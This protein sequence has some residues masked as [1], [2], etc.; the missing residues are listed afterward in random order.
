MTRVAHVLRKFDPSEWGGTETHVAE[1]TQRMLPLGFQGEVH[2]PAGPSDRSGLHP[3]IPLYRYAA[4]CPYLGPKERRRAL[5]AS[6]GNIVSFNLVTRLAFDRDVALAHL[7]TGN[8]IGGGVRTAMRLTGR[9]YVIS[10]HGPLLA[11]P[12]L[13]AAETERRYDGLTDLGKPLGLL[14]GAR[15]VL[16]DAA[17]V[18]TFND[19]EHRAVGARVGGRAVR[20]DHGVDAARLSGGDVERARA[21]WPELGQGPVVALLG[22]ICAQKNQILAVRAFAAGAPP[23]HRLALPGAETDPGYRALVEREARALG[24]ADRVHF[25]GNIDRTRDVPDLLAR[26][27]LVVVPSTHEAFGLAV[28]EAWAASRPVLFAGTAGLRDLGRAAGEGAPLVGTLEVD[29]WA[30]ELRRYLEQAALREAAAQTGLR[31]V[32]ERFGWDAVVAKLAALYEEVLAEAGR[33]RV[34]AH[35]SSARPSASA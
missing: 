27:S 15:R 19:D 5:V 23:D 4:F 31:L 33:P 6:S 17:R 10:I 18:I 34:R 29:A 20:M 12:E 13:V 8:R 25:L 35:A 9:P 16:D 14:L 28:L 7:H 22:R 11:Q 32:R 2:A 30:G 1:V 3:D 26:A 21:R 24:V